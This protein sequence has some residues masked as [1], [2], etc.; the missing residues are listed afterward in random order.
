MGIFKKIIVALVLFWLAFTEMQAQTIPYA[1]S[2]QGVA[3]DASGLILPNQS[4]RVKAGIYA[5]SATGMLEWE[6][7]QTA[8]TDFAGVFH[9]TIGQ[10]SS[11]GNGSL[12]S[13]NLINWGIA[14]HYMKAEIDY[15]GGSSF[16][17]MGTS[18]F[19]SVPYA[20][21]SD[22]ARTLAGISI[23]SLTDVDTAGNHIG[24]MLKWNGSQWVPKPDNDRDTVS[25][26]ANAG[27]VA[28]TGTS[29]YALHIMNTDDTVHFANIS[30]PAV[31]AANAQTTGAVSTSGTSDTTGYAAAFV[32]FNWSVNGNAPGG[33]VNK[34]GTT[35]SV[36]FTIRTNNLERLRVTEN[37][38]L[39]IGVTAPQ[40]NLQITGIDGLLHVGTFGSG[41]TTLSYTNGT[42][43]MWSP[44]KGAFHAGT[45]SGNQWANGRTGESSF[46]IG[47]NSTVTGGG[48]YSAA[49]GD[50][51]SVTCTASMAMGNKCYTTI[52]SGVDDGGSFAMGDSCVVTFTRSVAMGY[53]CRSNG[54]YSFGGYNV[55]N[56]GTGFALGSYNTTYN[57]SGMALGSHASTNTHSGC[58]IFA[59][60]SSTT[61]TNVPANNQFVVR[62]SG[63]VIFYSD[64][65]ATM[66]VTLFPGGGSWASVSDRNKKENFYTPDGE[67]ILSAIAGLKITSW[68]YKSQAESI[69]HIGPMAQDFYRAFKLGESRKRISM[70]DID[71]VT[72]LA[73][74]TLYTRVTILDAS[75]D[76]MHQLKAEAKNIDNDDDALN[77]RLD[78][79][80]KRLIQQ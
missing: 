6:E 31:Y 51:S 18:Q 33:T 5:G 46:S 56:G 8:S 48:F 73:L 16:V 1:I 67:E 57:G 34:L 24:Y 15:N 50:S 10:G 41:D 71:G 21:Y 70:V 30:G 61:Q 28:T 35:D 45:V 2:Y 66:G 42:Y 14:D 64:S 74:K 22:K 4:I 36:P 47:Y 53:H 78:N 58:F 39:G 68:N 26:A 20:F 52:L 23:N 49:F 3:R 43:L 60:A 37:G 62:A 76:A 11:T 40:A 63:G 59:D 9:I 25:Y 77:Q 44:R 38:K 7:T 65:T 80:Q 12:S 29:A 55:T 13:F 32:P 19:V 72:M 75:F 79:I 27:H 69:R 17:S 54:G